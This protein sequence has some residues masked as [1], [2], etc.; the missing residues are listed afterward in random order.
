MEGEVFLPLRRIGSRGRVCGRRRATPHRTNRKTSDLRRTLWTNRP[1]ELMVRLIFS[2]KSG[3][4]MSTN[5]LA[6]N[7]LSE[8]ERL[9]TLLLRRLGNRIRDLRVIVLPGG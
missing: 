5:A 7:V 2:P 8:E 1:S 4:F 6:T 3:G 9:E